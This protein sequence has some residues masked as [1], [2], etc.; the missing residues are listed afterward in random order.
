MRRSQQERPSK[1]GAGRIGNEA[2]LAH[3]RAI[4]AE[5]KQEY[6][7]PR[8]CKELVARGSVLGYVS[9]MQYE[10]SWGAAQLSKAA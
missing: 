9:P 2:L 7:L 4:H 1:P 10:E 3:I 8:M 5:V 6:G